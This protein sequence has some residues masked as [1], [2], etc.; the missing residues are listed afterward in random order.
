MSVRDGEWA[1]FLVLERITARGAYLNLALSGVF[2]ELELMGAARSAATAM[3]RTTMEHLIAVDFA[4]ATVTDTRRCGRAV[5]NILR[6]GAA[7][8]LYMDTEDAVAVNAAV[9]LCKRAGKTAQA[10]YVNGVMR[11]FAADKHRIPWPRRENDDTRY[12]S[13]QYSWPLWAVKQAV[14]QLG[15]EQAETML[16]QQAQNYIPLRVNRLKTTQKQAADAIRLV[17]G[18]VDVSPYDPWMLRV[19]YCG[20]ITN[21]NAYQNGLF[22]LQ[23]EASMFAARQIPPCANTIMDMCAAPGGKTFAIAECMPNAIILAFDVHAHR[24]AMMEKQRGRL[25]IENVTC[26]VQDVAQLMEERI[27]SADAVL[28]D[29]PCSGMGTALKRPDVKQN[30]SFEDVLS[31][32]KLQKDI[33]EMSAQYVKNGGILVYCTCTFIHQENRDVIEEFLHRHNDFTLIPLDLP[34]AF[35]DEGRSGMLQLWPHIHGTDGFFMARMQRH[36]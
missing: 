6:L 17:G 10:R 35:N 26:A 18:Q 7:R 25:G 4:L 11:A 29:A 19:R 12:L 36:G 28:I 33:L 15:F 23:G 8:I 34:R 30:R 24:V 16:A 13:I 1:A 14:R 3:A 27:R 32:N 20:D 2:D 22:S 9:E 31:L 21:I 5:K